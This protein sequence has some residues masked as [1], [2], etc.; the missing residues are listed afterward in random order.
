MIPFTRP[1]RLAAGLD[2]IREAFE[3]HTIA[4]D[5]PFGKRVEKQLASEIPPP[6]ERGPDAFRALLEKDSARVAALV[7]AI[8]LKPEN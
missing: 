2:R 3:G 7:K 1:T 5:G 6:A 4:G 8:G